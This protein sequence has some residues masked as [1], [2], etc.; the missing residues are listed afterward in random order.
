[1]NA[2]NLK[3]G[4]VVVPKSLIGSFHIECVVSYANVPDMWFEIDDDW[5]NKI[6]MEENFYTLA[7]SFIAT[8]K[9]KLKKLQNENKFI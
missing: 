6:D 7:E 3:I 1:M 4:D 2:R 5:V 9:L 8:R